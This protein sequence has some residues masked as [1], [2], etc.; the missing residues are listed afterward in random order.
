[1]NKPILNGRQGNLD[2]LKAFIADGDYAPGDR[3]PA[4]RELIGA[5]GMKRTA[6]RRALDAL[7]QEG[8]IWRHVGKGTFLAEETARPSDDFLVD[9]SRQITPVKVMRARLAFEPAIAREAAI[10]ASNEAVGRIQRAIEYGE[11]AEDWTSYETYDDEFHK[12]IAIA[13][14]NMLLVSLYDQMNRVKRKLAW[15]KVVR[16]T[17]RPPRSHTSFAEHRVIAEA[18]EAHDPNGA[19]DAMRRHIVSVSARLFEEL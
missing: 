7:E 19:R 12:A 2:S 4:E 5:L 11:A 17:M 3:L 13:S 8:L 9:M 1:M 14:D 6:L 15:G 18:I 10:N 16:E